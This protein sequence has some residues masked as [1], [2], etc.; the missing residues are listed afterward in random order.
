MPAVLLQ[1]CRTILH[2]RGIGFN[3]R[4]HHHRCRRPP[5]PH[6]LPLRPPSVLQRAIS[7][8]PAGRGVR[9]SGSPEGVTTL[10]AGFSGLCLEG[11]CAYLSDFEPQS[12]SQRV[13]PDLQKPFWA[14]A[15]PSPFD[16]RAV[17]YP[18]PNLT[19]CRWRMRRRFTSRRGRR[20]SPKGSRPV[21]GESARAIARS[22]NVH[23]VLKLGLPQ[24]EHQIG[25]DAA[26][27]PHPARRTARVHPAVPIAQASRH[28]KGC[29]AWPATS[30]VLGASPNH[31][32]AVCRHS[33]RRA[34]RWLVFCRPR[35]PRG[36]Y[37]SCQ[38]KRLPMG[39]SRT[40]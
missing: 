10:R 5:P 14:S 23:H 12:L 21:A 13:A 26:H 34:N 35:C 6:G 30:S 27:H 33:A 18:Y 2:E 36:P 31:L 29:A 1:R 3:H 16:G 7:T 22:F 17:R 4:A 24:V 20:S 8:A 32:T 19:S 28:S 11:I 37:R 9:D 39:L 15:G 25:A 38:C 40:L